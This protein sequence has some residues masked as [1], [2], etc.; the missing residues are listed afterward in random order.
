MINMEIGNAISPPSEAVPP[1]IS[2][3]ETQTAARPDKFVTFHL[4]EATYAVRAAMVAEVAQVL[5]LTPL[6]G[7]KPGIVGIS[8]LRGE[9]VAKIDLRTMLGERPANSGNPKVKE[10]VLKRPFPD[11]VPVAFA[12]DRLGEIATLDIA[13][14]RPLLDNNGLFIGEVRWSERSLRVIDHRMLLASIEPD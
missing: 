12:V 6:P 8:P 1:P 3:N 7:T 4:G 5:P 14:I 13:Q 11:A 2:A 10:I 9:I